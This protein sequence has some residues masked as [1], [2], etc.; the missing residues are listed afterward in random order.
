[1]QAKIRNLMGMAQ[2]T[3]QL[4]NAVNYNIYADNSKNDSIRISEIKHNKNLSCQ[5]AGTFI[6]R[7]NF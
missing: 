5:D 1:M 2:V 3:T 6:F 7:T 4:H